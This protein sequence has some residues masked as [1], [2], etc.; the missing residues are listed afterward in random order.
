MKS[1]KTKFDLILERLKYS[2]RN[3]TVHGPS[4]LARRDVNFIIRFIYFI[5]YINV[6]IFAIASIYKYISTYQEDT[7]RFTTRTDYLDWNTTFPSITI[8]EN[9]NI[10]KISTTI[11]NL[12]VKNQEETTLFAKEIAFFTGECHNCNFNYE[13]DFMIKKEIINLTTA[14]RSDCKDLFVSCLWDG[15]PMNCCEHFKPIKTE[16]GLCYTLNNNQVEEKLTPYYVASSN[17]RRLGALELVLSQDSEAFLHSPDDVPY[18]N[19]ENDRRAK[20]PNGFGASILFSIVDIVNEPEVSLTAPEVRQC[21]F[22]NESPENFKG[23][24]YYSYSVCIIQCRI[25]AQFELCNCISHLSP[26]EYSDYY[27]DTEGLKCLTKHYRDLKKLKVSGINETG[28]NCDCPPSCVEPD[29]NI[30]SNKI[31]EPEGELTPAS[32]K[33]ILS[34]RPY[35]RVTRQI[36][37]TT[38]DLVVSMGN[39]FGLCFGGSILSIVEV[40][41]YICFKQWKYTNVK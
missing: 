36:A 40:L 35:E 14:F 24:K 10:N 33:F 5:I 27:C 16:Y 6:W 7:I 11:Q 39:C 31:Y 13:N 26:I 32:L 20:V 18:W 41:Y 8:C 29:Y 38:L 9:A 17:D 34:N 25:E 28:L 22:P 2:C 19:M 3:L 15:K 30:I 37:R 1:L 12:Q 23:Y 21:R 4:F